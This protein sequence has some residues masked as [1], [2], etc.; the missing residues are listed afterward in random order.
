MKQTQHGKQRTVS[1]FPGGGSAVRAAKPVA[2]PATAA[3]DG[4]VSASVA[5]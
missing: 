4:S 3:P 2:S 5:V 1:G